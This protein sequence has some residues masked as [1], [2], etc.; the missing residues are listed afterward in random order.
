MNRLLFTCLLAVLP[1]VSFG[2][3]LRGVV[4]EDTNANGVRDDGEP[5]IANVLVTGGESTA[6]TDSDGAYSMDWMGMG[7]LDVWVRVPAEYTVPTDKVTNVPQFYK[8]FA[9]EGNEFIK[10]N[11]VPE[12]VDFGLLKRDAA[13]ASDKFKVVVISDPQVGS[14]RQVDEYREDVLCELVGTD[15]DFVTVLGDYSGDKP[16]LIS[17]VATVTGL[18]GRPVYGVMGNHD[19]VAAAK[20]AEESDDAFNAVCGPVYYSFDR[21]KAHFVVLNTVLYTE[22]GHGYKEGVDDGQ[23]EWLKTDLESVPKDKLIVLL[24]H[25]PLFKRDGTLQTGVDKLMQCVEGRDVMSLSG[26]WHTNS[27]L[28]VGEAQGWKSTDKKFVQQVCPVACGSF[29]CGP[30]DLRGIPTADQPDGTPNGYT[31]WEFDGNKMPVGTYKA[32]SLPESNQMRILTPDLLGGTHYWNG[33]LLVNY[34]MGYDKSKV[35]Y[36]ANG[37]EWVAMERKE[38]I[39]PEAAQ[40]IDGVAAH[41]WVP[42]LWVEPSKH[43]W[44]T[45]KMQ[46]LKNGLNT[47][48]VRATEPDGRVITQG[49]A[50]KGYVKAEEKK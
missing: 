27:R 16:E 24:S 17:S 39:D 48:V 18:L 9:T 50:F 32:A 43:I 22:P 4:Y 38:M 47:I 11:E 26:H 44:F 46:G 5:G 31:I 35:E 14:Q 23:L 3:P 1:L 10:K 8:I 45:D 20:S 12:S 41:R 21:G 7:E 15:A 33:G 34:Y 6:M 49:R 25:C 2:A 37:G 13:A 29:W 40:M 30:A 19:R 28:D 42:T 36:S